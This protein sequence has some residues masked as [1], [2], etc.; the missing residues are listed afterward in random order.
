ML[1]AVKCDSVN[2]SEYKLTVIR[3]FIQ[4]TTKTEFGGGREREKIAKEKFKGRHNDVCVIHH[5]ICM[6]LLLCH[7]C[8]FSP[9]ISFVNKLLR[10]VM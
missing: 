2:V 5:C 1:H 10:V 3:W 6:H 4:L 8:L 9:E 7:L